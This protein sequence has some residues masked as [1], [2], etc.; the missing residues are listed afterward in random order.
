MNCQL[1]IIKSALK[2][3]LAK[4]RITISEFNVQPA[5]QEKSIEKYKNFGGLNS[6]LKLYDSANIKLSDKKQ[7][8]LHN[9]RQE[10]ATTTTS[11][12]YGVLFFAHPHF[13]L[14]SFNAETHLAH[15]VLPL[16]DKLP[17][18]KQKEPNFPTLKKMRKIIL[19][20]KNFFICQTLPN[21]IHIIN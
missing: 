6:Y 14:F 3:F 20:I 1:P 5:C 15:F 11:L 7:E 13:L 16:P 17:N 18:G 9:M 4:F 10:L 2:N 19:V 8:T 12:R 21:Q